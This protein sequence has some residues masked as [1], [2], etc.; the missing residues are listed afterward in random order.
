LPEGTNLTALAPHFETSLYAHVYVNGQ[1]QESGITMHDFTESVAYTVIAEDSTSAEY[2]VYISTEVGLNVFNVTQRSVYPNP[3][4]RTLKVSGELPESI[5][6]LDMAGRIILSQTLNNEGTIDVNALK[7][8][9]YFL[10]MQF[11]NT[12]IHVERFIKTE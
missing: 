5:V 9:V 10:Q 2:I 11:N 1:I 4:S 12:T 7:S 3:T 8:G 6:V